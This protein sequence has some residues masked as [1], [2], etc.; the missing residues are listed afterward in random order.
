MSLT[1]PHCSS[2]FE[3]ASSALPQQAPDVA[4]KPEDEKDQK[5]PCH[6]QL[7]VTTPLPADK[8]VKLVSD[9]DLPDDLHVL[10][11][12]YDSSKEVLP[13]NKEDTSTIATR[14]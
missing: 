2:F 5:K 12:D 6:V 13:A 8:E 3:V 9:D 7:S 4:I 1:F 11:S 14:H 10:L